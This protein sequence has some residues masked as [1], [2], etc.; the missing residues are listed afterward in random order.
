MASFALIRYELIDA[1]VTPGPQS[2]ERGQPSSPSEISQGK[3]QLRLR[4][5]PPFEAV[6]ALLPPPLRLQ[7]HSR[8]F[9]PPLALLSR[10]F[11]TTL[12]LGG[13]GF[14]AAL[15]G[16]TAYAWEGLQQNVG[17]FTTSCLGI[18]LLAGIWAV[19]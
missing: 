15:V 12:A 13:V 5:I 8:T 7:A 6:Q 9:T 3:Q 10:C 14:I 18:S 16:I 11:Y 19:L 4:P 2:N 1:E 17:I